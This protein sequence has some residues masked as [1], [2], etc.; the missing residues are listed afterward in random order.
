MVRPG[1]VGSLGLWVGKRRDGGGRKISQ[2]EPTAVVGA[3][4]KEWGVSQA[5]WVGLVGMW[6]CGGLPDAC[7]WC[8]GGGAG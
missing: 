4:E 7:R 5:L 8:E 2:G 6:G 3:P 1:V